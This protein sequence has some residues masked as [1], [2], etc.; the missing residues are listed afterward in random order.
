MRFYIG[1]NISNQILDMLLKEKIKEQ[2][3]FPVA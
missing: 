1:V 2:N 3:D